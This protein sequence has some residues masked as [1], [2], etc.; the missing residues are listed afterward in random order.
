VN[1]EESFPWF[2]FKEKNIH[3]IELSSF[4][5]AHSATDAN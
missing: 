5:D 1:E 3:E 2:K 4:L